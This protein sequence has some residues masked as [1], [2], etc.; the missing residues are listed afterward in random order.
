MNFF[1]IL[2]GT[3]SFA[4]GSKSLGIG[5]LSRVTM[6]RIIVTAPGMARTAKHVLYVLNVS[7]PVLRSITRY[8][9]TGP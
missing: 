4:S 7:S 6:R 3:Y 2:D 1:F 9:R 5:K 8:S